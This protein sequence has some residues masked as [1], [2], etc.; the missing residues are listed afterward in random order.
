MV[1]VGTLLAFTSHVASKQ[2]VYEKQ[3]YSDWRLTFVFVFFHTYFFLLWQISTLAPLL[4]YFSNNTLILSNKRHYIP[5][6]F[7]IPSHFVIHHDTICNPWPTLWCILSHFV[8]H[9]LSHFV[10]HLWHTL[11][12]TEPSHFV[13]RSCHTL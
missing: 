1:E 10:A 11:S 2:R 13:T 8:M 6:H 12:S 9:N 4:R 5:P 7:V 3:K